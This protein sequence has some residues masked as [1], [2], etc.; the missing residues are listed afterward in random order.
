MVLVW[1]ACGARSFSGV[2]RKIDRHVDANSA[3]YDVAGIAEVNIKILQ[4][5]SSGQKT[6]NNSHSTSLTAY[7][8]PPRSG[9]RGLVVGC[10]ECWAPAKNR[11]TEG[12][13]QND[14]LLLVII[15]ILLLLVV[16]QLFST[17]VCTH[18]HSGFLQEVAGK[19]LKML[20]SLIVARIGKMYEKP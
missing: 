15:L 11:A 3:R 16:S 4:Q 1:C 6:E 17:F 13:V 9:W 19:N 7:G 5:T 20:F 18:V 12:A 14:S 10:C 8:K 2:V